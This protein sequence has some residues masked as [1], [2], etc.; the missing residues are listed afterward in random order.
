[1][2]TY[3]DLLI[4]TVCFSLQLYSL[5]FVSVFY[6]ICIV[7]GRQGDVILVYTV[8]TWRVR[9]YQVYHVLALD[10]LVVSVVLNTG[11]LILLLTKIFGPSIH[12]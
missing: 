5:S 3:V 4:T 10:I 11:T 2:R 7:S 9:M 12:I 8:F 6:I 1:M